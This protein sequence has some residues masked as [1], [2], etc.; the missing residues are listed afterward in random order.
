MKRLL[1][2]IVLL[3]PLCGCGK[4]DPQ[5]EVE[6]ERS[7]SGGVSVGPVSVGRDKASDDYYKGPASKAPDWTK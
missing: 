1:L 3:V 2:M 6:C 5:I 4:K 7:G